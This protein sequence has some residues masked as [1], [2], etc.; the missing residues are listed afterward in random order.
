MITNTVTTDL[1]NLL[2]ELGFGTFGTTLFYGRVPDSKKTAT[3]I[4]W[5]TPESTSVSGT[6][7][8]TGEEKITFSYRIYYRSMDYKTV[9]ANILAAIKTLSS[10][11]C[12]S[13]NNYTTMEIRLGSMNS[14]FTI[15]TENRV[16]GYAA[17]TVKLYDIASVE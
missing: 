1:L 10:I 11:Q 8:V 7:N 13:L 15:D 3:E 16:V 17:F 4:W 2:Q 6:Q 5:V 12:R 9:D 14:N